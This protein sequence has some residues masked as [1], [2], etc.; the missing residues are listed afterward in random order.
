MPPLQPRVSDCAPPTHTVI[1]SGCP[2]IR[3]HRPVWAA[4]GRR[5]VRGRE[6]E[7]ATYYRRHQLV[8]PLEGLSDSGCA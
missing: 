8:L 6:D 2:T 4:K 7:C 5:I 3:H 1:S